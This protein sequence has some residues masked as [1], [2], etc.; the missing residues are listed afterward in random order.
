MTENEIATAVFQCGI[1]IHKSLGPGLL[2]KIYEEC[3]CVELEQAG[4][5]FER[6]Q[7]I[8]IFYSGKQLNTF[9]QADLIVENKVLIEIKSVNELSAI[10]HAQIL[11]YLKLTKPKLGLLINFNV[12]LFKHGFKRVVLGEID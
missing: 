5:K 7:P 10:H 1:K 3:L 9:F 8:P 2:E 12:P 6:Q 4:I 11:T